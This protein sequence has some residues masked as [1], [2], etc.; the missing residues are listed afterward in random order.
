MNKRLRLIGLI[1]AFIGISALARAADPP[2][3]SLPPG[4]QVHRD[5]EYVAG[6][7][8]RNKLDLYLPA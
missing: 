7:H 6:G 1:A 4:V 2:K 5:L 3:A 8:A